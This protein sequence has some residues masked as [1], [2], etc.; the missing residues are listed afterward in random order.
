[1]LTTL[2]PAQMKALEADFMAQTG[3]PGAVLMELAAHAVTEAVARH[4]PSGSRVLFLCGQGRI[5]PMCSAHPL[6][7]A[8]GSLC[9]KACTQV[10][11]ILPYFYPPL[12]IRRGGA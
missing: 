2:T 5:Y 4:A 3:V 1:M 8:S 12:I 11:Y 7:R 10:L 9:G 6:R